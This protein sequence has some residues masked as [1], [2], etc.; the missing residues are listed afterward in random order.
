MNQFNTPRLKIRVKVSGKVVECEVV[1]TEKHSCLVKLPN[2]DII[3][4]KIG[5]D[6]I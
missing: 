4:R 1:K 3:Q 5:R 2:G 6:V